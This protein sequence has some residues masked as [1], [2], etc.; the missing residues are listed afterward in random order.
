MN[1]ILHIFRK[2]VRRLWPLIAILFI[3]I[4]VHAVLD[5]LNLPFI[6]EDSRVLLLSQISK[7]LLP[8]CI[9]LLIAVTVFQE[10]LPNDQEFWLTRP[11]HRWNLF[12]AKVLFFVIFINFP[13]FISDCYILGIQGFPVLS[14][15][16]DLFL[17]QI[18][19]TI[20]FVLPHLMIATV[21]SGV[22]QFVLG[23]IV[24]ILAV[25]LQLVAITVVAKHD[26]AVS[27][28]AIPFPPPF[29]LAIV[30]LAVLRWQYF[31]R[32]TTKSRAAILSCALFA[33]PL[34]F[35]FPSFKEATPPEG[36]S[37]IRVE[38][39]LKVGRSPISDRAVPSPTQAVIRIPMKVE[40]LPPKTL[41]RG[42]GSFSI[43][44]N[45]KSWPEQ[46]MKVYATVPREYGVY[47]EEFRIPV[48][49]LSTLKE[50]V[51]IHSTLNF[52]V[53]TNEVKFTASVDEPLVI[54]PGIGRCFS[55]REESSV[56]LACRAGLGNIGETEIA[57]TSKRTVS[58]RNGYVPALRLLPWGLSP[59]TDVYHAAFDSIPSGSKFEFI[60]HDPIVKFS[61]RL[62]LPNIR[63]ADF[64]V[65][66]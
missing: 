1:Q 4:A 35:I 49:T 46:R 2:D 19:V 11:Y 58:P 13:L 3:L 40:G 45:G 48:S 9:W 8:I 41:F 42:Q 51:N 56:H 33:F 59:V 14:S 54:A 31:K 26:S 7:L 30:F 63:L 20:L 16:P 36:K 29:A 38:Y 61:R 15:L 66:P 22:G 47:W 64:V 23:W 25:V 10:A 55:S 12:A 60:P 28:Q 62:D 65:N 21:T 50:P 17:R 52:E 39:D 53:L 34:S 44:A 24:L 37:D 57:A 5:V 43:D 18:Q 6:V 27:M 32:E